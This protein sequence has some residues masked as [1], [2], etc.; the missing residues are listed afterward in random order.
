MRIIATH[1]PAPPPPPPLPAG[2]FE[3]AGAGLAVP[4]AVL[5]ETCVDRPAMGDGLADGVDC[6][7]AAGTGAGLGAG[8]EGLDAA[9]TGAGAGRGAGAGAA[10]FAAAGLA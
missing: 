4:G 7:R 1:F 5:A 3:V 10:G 9:A 6:A 2:F 8:A